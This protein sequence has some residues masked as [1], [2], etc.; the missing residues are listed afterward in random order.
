MLRLIPEPE[1]RT[2]PVTGAYDPPLLRPTAQLVEAATSDTQSAA[3]VDAG[4]EAEDERASRL[5]TRT[6]LPQDLSSLW[7][8]S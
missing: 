3:K 5:P 2:V 6:L 8:C 7:I 1:L 4:R